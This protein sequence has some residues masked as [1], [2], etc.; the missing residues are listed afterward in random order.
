VLYWHYKV[1]TAKNEVFV[2]RLR[3][4]RLSTRVDEIIKCL[5]PWTIDSG[6]LDN[7]PIDD[8][9]IRLQEASSNQVV[10]YRVASGKKAQSLLVQR[11]KDAKYALLVIAGNCDGIDLA[12]NMIRVSDEEFLN[13]QRLVLD[14]LYPN[15]ETMKLIGVTGTN[16]KTTV[17]GLAE[18]I[19]NSLGHTAISAGTIGVFSK[20]VRVGDDFGNTTPSYIDLRKFIYRYQ[21]NYQ[22]LFFE[23]SSHA[24][25]QQRIFDL[26]LDGALWTSFSQDHLD[27]HKTMEGYFQAKLM[28]AT[29]ALKAK[30]PLLLPAR[31]SALS[32]RVRE[33]FSR[34]KIC[35][36]LEERGFQQVPL[37]F[38]PEYNRSNLELALQINCELWGELTE[39]NLDSL[40]APEGRFSTLEVGDSLVVVDYAHTPEALERVLM[41]IRESFSGRLL[42]VLFG[43]G[44]DRDRAKRP[45]MGEVAARLADRVYITSDNPRSEDPAK[46]IEDIANALDTKLAQISIETD[47]TKSI[48]SALGQLETD[49]ILLIA[50]KGHE[51]YQEIAGE[52][53]QFSDFEVVKK[54]KH[55]IAGRE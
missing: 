3:E 1:L 24:L 49:E 8:V 13:S 33:A 34:V 45:M 52:R 44:G 23:L 19:S 10:F 30:L 48:E 53:L 50:G 40:Q 15:K 46:I 2:D 9:T 28:I 27:F 17:V 26:R 16:G 25:V 14:L 47:R 6:T 36:T 31:E 43:C 42:S 22:V 39:V 51:Q 4:E 41:A 21:D 32:E 20:G 37:F 54:Y 11:M 55:S 7:L 12:N 5:Q 38:M 29:S 18:Q 35:P